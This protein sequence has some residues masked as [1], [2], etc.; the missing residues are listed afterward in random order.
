VSDIATAAPNGQ[1]STP[2]IISADARVTAPHG[3]KGLVLGPTGVGKTTLLRTLDPG[4]TL[5]M[6][7]EAGDL[8]VQDLAVDALR[9]RTWPECRDLAVALAGADP[10]VS[11]AACYSAGHYTAVRD[12]FDPEQLNRYQT[13]FIDSI[14][15]AGRLCFAWSSQQPEA[16]NDRG[17]KDL[18]GAY[19]LHAREM[20]AWLMHLQQAR[21]I[22]VIFLGILETVVD[23]FNR[24]EHRL[25]MEGSRT[26]RELPGIVDQVITYNWLD[27]GDGVLTRGFICTSPNYWGYPAKDRSGRLDQIE[28]PHLGKLI[29]KLTRPRAAASSDPQPLSNSNSK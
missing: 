1:A 25:Q 21:S 18:R 17:K 4:T 14:T 2:K 16:F 22:N 19:G 11:D 9:P 26:G 12:H 6:D 23:D 3:V 8:A 29:D 28:E 10:A 20:L 5:F 15:A 24:T 13:Y 7:V 27:F